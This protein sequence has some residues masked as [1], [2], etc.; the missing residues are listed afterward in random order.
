MKKIIKA[1]QVF[2]EKGAF[3]QMM[4]KKKFSFASY[5]IN[6]TL[7]GKIETLNTIIDA[8]ANQ[9]QFALMASVFFPE[10]KIYSYEPLPDIYPVLEKNTANYKSQISTFNIALGDKD[11]NIKFYKNNYSHVSSALPIDN[12]NN[13][14]NYS[15]SAANEITVPLSTIDTIASSVEIKKPCLLKLDV[16][17]FEKEVINGAKNTLGL[18]DYI[19]LEMPFYKLY[20]NQPLFNELNALLNEKGFEL[21]LPMDVNYGNDNAIIE[22]DFL[23]KRKTGNI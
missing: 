18:I 5:K 20:E 13:H 3:K 2:S 22:I 6:R 23:Y 16:Q 15:Q 17:G 10:A 14:P 8:G 9:G 19:L 21:F 1:L 11:A 12:K 4:G 7:K